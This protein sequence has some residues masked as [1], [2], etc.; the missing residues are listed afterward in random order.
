[1][2]ARSGSVS[3]TS[4][5]ET[6]DDE[7]DPEAPKQPTYLKCNDFMERTLCRAARDGMT[8]RMM[9][10]LQERIDPN[11]KDGSGYTPLHLAAKTGQYEAL[12]LLINNG[13]KVNSVNANG[14]TPLH[15]AAQ[16]DQ[17]KCAQVL[18]L[19]GAS[20]VAECWSRVRP[21]HLTPENSET[22]GMLEEC[23]L[24]NKSPNPRK[25]F[26][27]T[28]QPIVPSWSIPTLTKE[29]V[30]MLRARERSKKK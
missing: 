11:C 19:A 29:Q 1:M 25:V 15:L 8:Y 27:L 28:E 24:H 2:M 17:L 14:V 18:L 30:K 12:K 6:T 7:Y 16:F 4:K 9:R 5:Q 23:I 26:D 13:A 10:I 20:I 21:L 22:R 3:V